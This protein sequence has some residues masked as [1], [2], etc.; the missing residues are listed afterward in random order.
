MKTDKATLHYGKTNQMQ[1]SFDLLEQY[2]EQC[3][4]SVRAD[5]QLDPARTRFP[6]IIDAAH[7]Y[8]PAAG[9]RAAHRYHPD[10]AWCVVAC[11]LPLLENSIIQSLVSSRKIGMDGVILATGVE[12]VDIDPLCAV[13]EPAALAHLCQQQDARYPPLRSCLSNAVHLSLSNPDFLLNANTPEE[14]K[15]ALRKIRNADE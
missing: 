7:E 10:V 9:L 14:H 8:G 11:D 6:H 12:E 3:F 15:L 2:V 4:I 13:W 5:Q 1:R